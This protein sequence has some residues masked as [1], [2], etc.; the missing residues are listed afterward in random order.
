MGPW[1]ERAGA[2]RLRRWL[3]IAAV[4]VLV[5]LLLVVA[6]MLARGTGGHGP[7]RHGSEAQSRATVVL[8]DGLTR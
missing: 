5:L 1:P 8:L 6:M 7:S 3:T 4:A 2:E